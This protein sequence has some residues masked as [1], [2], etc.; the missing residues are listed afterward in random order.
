MIFGHSPSIASGHV[1]MA[2]RTGFTVDR[3]GRLAVNAGF[4]ETRVLEGE[5]YDLWAALLMPKADATDLASLFE[6]TNI[7]ALFSDAAS[8]R[9]GR[10]TPQARAHPAHL[11][12]GKALGLASP[13]RETQPHAHEDRAASC[14]DSPSKCWR[15]K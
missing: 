6:D 3:L 11:M 14:P 1:H 10:E 13:A 9:A 7:A 2:H 12:P 8:R 5:N 4:A 15:T